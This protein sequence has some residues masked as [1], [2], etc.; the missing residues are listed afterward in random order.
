M[1]WRELVFPCHPPP[2]CAPIPEEYLTLKTFFLFQKMIEEDYLHDEEEIK[3][4]LKKK[5]AKKNASERM[6]DTL[7]VR[8]SAL[9]KEQLMQVANEDF[10]AGVNLEV[11]SDFFILIPFN[12]I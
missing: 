6:G 2:C 1:L 4:K 3:R 12:L 5:K 10:L 8:K 9:E 7:Q 11:S